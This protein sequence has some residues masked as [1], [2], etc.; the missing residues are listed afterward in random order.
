M[1]QGKEIDRCADILKALGHPVRMQIVAGL[2]CDNECNV[3]RIVE[4]LNLPQSTISQHLSIL[5]SRNIIEAEKHGVSICY[6]VTDDR[7]KKI[8]RIFEI[9]CDMK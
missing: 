1:T 4:S 5:K 9:K 7:V 8:I 3:N 2:M 6:K